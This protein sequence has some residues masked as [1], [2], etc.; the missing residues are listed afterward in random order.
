MTAMEN[1]VPNRIVEPLTEETLIKVVAGLLEV[2]PHE[3]RP[4][5]NLIEKGLHSMQLIKLA[6]K[7][8]RT[9]ADVNFAA[10][11]LEP[12]VEAW[13]KLV[14]SPDTTPAG[15]EHSEA[16]PSDPSRGEPSR[17][18]F[19]LAVM[20]HGYWVG[21]QEGQSLGGVSAHLYA[22]F[23]GAGVDPHRLASAVRSLI[24]RHE[25]LRSQFGDDGR[26]RIL[27]EPPQSVF[28]I[29]DLRELAADSVEANLDLLRQN[30]SHQRMDIAG[31]QVIDITLS[32]LPQGDTRL[33]VD[34]DMLAADGM[35]YRVFLADLADYYLGSTELPD[36][37]Y[38]YRSYLVDHGVSTRAAHEREA[39]WWAEQIPE[40]PDAPQL[41]L[42]PESEQSDPLA[43][44][45]YEYW[46][47]PEQKDVLTAR[48]HAHG[49]TPAMALASAFAETVARWSTD[50]QFLL[51]LPLFDREPTHPDVDKLVGDFT[52][53]VL[54]NV[55]VR[56][57]KSLVDRARSL[58]QML[59]TNAAHSDYHGLDVLRDLGRF[60]GD[61]V[62]ASVV[63]TS[64][65]NMGELF[66]DSVRE[67]FGKPVWI[68]S[69]GPQV[70]LD[71]Q[72][73]ELGGGILLNWDVRRDAFPV[74]VMDAMFA[75]YQRS[76]DRLVDPESTWD[77]ST[78]D[79]LP[80]AQ[81]LVRER[82][83]GTSNGSAARTLHH[84][85][86]ELA[87]AAPDRQ[88]LIWSTGSLTYGELAAQALTIAHGLIDNS[89]HPGD[90]VA[91]RIPKGHRQVVAVLGAVAAGATYLPINP[92]HPAA[93]AELIHRKGRVTATLH[94]GAHDLGSHTLSL[95]LD[96]VLSRYSALPGPIDIEPDDL[97]YVLFTSGSTG[98]PKGVEVPHS[99]A[100]GTIDGII[101]HFGIDENDRTIGLSALEFDLSVFDIFAPLSLGGALV[102]IG[103]DET[104]DAQRWAHIIET[105]RVSVLNCAPGLLGMLLDAAQENQLAT[106]GTVILGGDWVAVELAERLRAAAPGSR[107]A[108]LGGATEA[109]IHST[110]CEVGHAPDPR[111]K[112]VPY[113]TPLPN[114]L[115]R[116]VNQRGQDA[117]DWV[118]GEL[119]IGGA[120]VARGYRGDPQRTSERFVDHDGHRWYRTGDLARY[121]P[122]GTIDFLGRRDHQ[123][124]IRG[125]RVELGEVESALRS[126][127]GI[128]QAVCTVVDDDAAR[129][130]TAAVTFITGEGGERSAP[131]NI[132]TQLAELLPAYMVPDTVEI[133][134]SMP[135]T[136]NGK[137]DRA[138][139][140]S[141][142]AHSVTQS[143]NAE[144]ST[145]LEAALAHIVADVL[146]IENIGVDRDFFSAGGD[147]VLATTVVSRIHRLLAV[148]DVKITD[149][150]AGRTVQKL[151]GRLIDKQQTPGRVEQIA[152]IYLD[153]V[154]RSSVGTRPEAALT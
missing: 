99:A 73:A 58:Q 45:R 128:D 39:R 131:D 46:L 101:E 14:A 37:D 90:T 86:F 121:L 92:D 26:Q 63:Y 38:S 65:L 35:S 77:H 118:A 53:S 135:L 145:S 137:L 120:G 151:A 7:W 89:V 21:R 108:G 64:G 51:N 80:A 60:R 140:T 79:D 4:D 148:S 69:Q 76:L 52:N 11:A 114:V 122:D 136:P 83:N 3:V 50:Q 103:D 123:V 22:E 105:L 10:L 34:V 18:D 113:G 17:D 71:A 154:G 9:G 8:R 152:D 95:S 119:W 23:D 55:D 19:P 6:A 127:P 117:P 124:K 29:N 129:R 72:V 115:C 43:S 149:M 130:L 93:R 68:M 125:Y 28:T 44:V 74:G 98:E 144:P 66:A 147:S 36:I 30:K 41:P 24:Q 56:E 15:S 143:G 20:Q 57:D 42:V 48:S 49:V 102:T 25:M 91:I 78:A 110:V 134:P 106:L 31:G 67:V 146:G 13:A 85:F 116:I 82:V 150:F 96:D 81:R 94:D 153:A 84:R 61:P 139:I 27:A 112:A 54:L 141:N 16:C 97:A 109:A 47:T 133:L 104:I 126:L 12:T 40:F 100:A 33:H 75:H 87:A 5:A 111:W 88:A 107:F 59:H 2:E 70:V 142:F 138:V 132:I 62:V 32:L 1:N